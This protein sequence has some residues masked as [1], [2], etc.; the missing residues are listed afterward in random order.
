MRIGLHSFVAATQLEKRL[1]T[2]TTGPWHS[3]A[4]PC[5]SAGV[6]DR[7]SRLRL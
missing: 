6:D 2:I 5:R 4:P 3:N 7:V 1:T